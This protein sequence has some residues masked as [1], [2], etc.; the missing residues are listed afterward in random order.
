MSIGVLQIHNGLLRYSRLPALA[1]PGQGIAP[2]EVVTLV[3]IGAAAALTALLPDLNWR[4]PGHAILRSV[5]PFALGLALVPRRG[6][7]TLMGSSALA[8][9]FSLQAA[10]TGPGA[11]S[12]TSLAL[13]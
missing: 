9:T 3:V 5:F 11:G 8:T 13:I 4:I 6:S 2:A 7:G 12:L 1:R 10:G